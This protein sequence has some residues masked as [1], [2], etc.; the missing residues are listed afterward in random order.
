[1]TIGAQLARKAAV[2]PLVWPSSRWLYAASPS[3]PRPPR[4]APAAPR[5]ELR[6]GRGPRR[7]R[8]W[9]RHFSGRA[10]GGHLSVL[11][12]L[13]AHGCPWSPRAC[14]SAAEGGHL[15][16]LQWLRANGCPWDEFTCEAAAG[17]G[18]LAVLEWARANGCPWDA[19]SCI[20][21]AS[22]G[23]LSVLQW[24]RAHALGM[25]TRSAAL[26]PR[27]ATSWC[28]SG[29][30]R[31][32]AR[33]GRTLM[34]LQLTLGSSQCCS[35]CTRMAARGVRA[36]ALL[37]LAVAISP[38][39]SGCACMAARG[40]TPR[41]T[42]QPSSAT[43]TCWQT[44]M[45]ALGARAR[46]S[47]WLRD[48]SSVLPSP[49]AAA[50]ASGGGSSSMAARGMIRSCPIQDGIA[51]PE[52]IVMNRLH[53][54]RRRRDGAPLARHAGRRLAIGRVVS[55]TLQLCKLVTLTHLAVT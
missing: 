34:G 36:C 1:V 7:V 25:R 5:T 15:S 20:N 32:A 53:S 43:S 46:S 26:R 6:L 27:A 17:V 9:R 42:V 31:M 18:H 29:C 8:H 52:R 37:Q 19:V 3:A 23:H 51:G 35:G 55:L 44:R 4:P 50:V 47:Q 16:V 30:A 33:G 14:G 2:G 24:L 48:W 13:R 54:S 45:A 39:C 10:R 38:C 40:I 22:D 41:A 12:W 49:S 11:L 21:A 28:C